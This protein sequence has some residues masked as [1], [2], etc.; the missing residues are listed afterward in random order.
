MRVLNNLV[1]FPLRVV[2]SALQFILNIFIKIECLVAGIVLVFLGICAVL[3]LINGMWLQLGIFAM[4]IVAVLILLFISAQIM[5]CVE[6][7]YDKI[8]EI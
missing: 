6:L 3:S 4:I 7:A 2:L 1:L 8:H 5:L